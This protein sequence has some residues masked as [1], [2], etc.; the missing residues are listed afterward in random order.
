MDNLYKKHKLGIELGRA[1]HN[2]EGF[3]EFKK[4]SKKLS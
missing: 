4:N 3:P 2:D 1:I